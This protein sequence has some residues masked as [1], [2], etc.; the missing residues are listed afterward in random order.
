MVTIR[1]FNYSTVWEDGMVK[2]VAPVLVAISVLG[3]ASA[4]KADSFTLKEGFKDGSA[5]PILEHGSYGSLTVGGSPNYKLGWTLLL[6]GGSTTLTATHTPTFVFSD[7]GNVSDIVRFNTDGAEIWSLGF[8]N[9]GL[10][11]LD[12]LNQ[13]FVQAQTP[14]TLK[15][16]NG[17]P[18]FG[19]VVKTDDIGL[20][21]EGPA[22]T[23][24]LK[25]VFWTGGTDDITVISTADA[26]AVVP[27]PATLTLMGIGGAM[28][29]FR[30]RRKTA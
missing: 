16:V 19:G 17:K 29:A 10:S 9:G 3:F 28:A 24:L 15:Q 2:F 18:V 5:D 4:A 12:I 23:A 22:G 25:G 6:D 7:T 30:R 13:A 14:G 26:N 20:V 1:L 8:N 11:F 21:G 27:E